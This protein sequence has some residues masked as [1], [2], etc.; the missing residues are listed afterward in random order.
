MCMPLPVQPATF[1]LS[2]SEKALLANVHT[3]NIDQTRAGVELALACVPTD[4][5]PRL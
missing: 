4:N 3:L 5:G 2:Q 1:M